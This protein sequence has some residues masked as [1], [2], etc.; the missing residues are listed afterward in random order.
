MEPRTRNI[1]ADRA[2]MLGGGSPPILKGAAVRSRLIKI[3]SLTVTCLGSVILWECLV[4][5]PM[6]AQPGTSHEPGGCTTAVISGSAT[7]SGRPLLWKNRDVLQPHQEIVYFNDG[8]FDYITIANAGD[9]TQAWGGV[10]SVGFAIEDA[11]NRNTSD[12]VPGPD[13]DGRICRLALQTCRTVDD[14]QA[15]LDSTSVAGHTRPAI[16]GVID[17][18]GGAAM[19]ET[20]CYSYVRYDADDP[21]DAPNGVLVRSNYSYA[22]DSIGWHGAYRHDRALALIEAALGGDT[23]DAKYV[24]RTV[25]RDLRRS[26]SF[27][28]YPLPYEGCDSVLPWGWIRT[29]GAISSYLTVSACVIEGIQPGEDPLLAT[30]WSM[31]MAVQCGIALPF[32]VA[33]RAT[34]PEV[35]GETTSPLCDEGLRIKTMAQHA[36]GFINQLD[37][38][39]LEDGQGGGLYRTT[40]PL[41]DSFFDRVDSALA[42]WRA[43]NAPDSA[44]MTDLTAQMAAEARAVLSAWPQPGDVCVMPKE[45]TGLTI[46]YEPSIGM[47][48]HWEAVTENYC[49]LPIEPSG[50]AVWAYDSLPFDP[51][52]A[53][54]LGFTKDSAFT[55]TLC[56]TPDLDLRFYNVRAWME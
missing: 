51:H 37:T 55:D 42:L 33:S 46:Q 35:N 15:L 13:D 19:F 53:D 23:L 4:A 27:D 14:F 45:V 24:C 16:F 50:Y 18:E 28:P 25:A 44:G 47:V 3:A 2:L 10:N 17:A 12:T 40:Y 26:A 43:A 5:E 56:L 1:T 49:G 8:Q 48:L 11:N 34:P 22:G 32:W 54:S 31:P 41:E 21:E 38:Y 7:A 20:F 6:R 36:Q 30:M 29:F 9:S 39:C 52:H